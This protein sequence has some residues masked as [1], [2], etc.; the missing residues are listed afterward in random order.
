[1]RT[2]S[3][4]LTRTNARIYADEA[5]L[6]NVFRRLKRSLPTGYGDI[7]IKV[8]GFGHFGKFTRTTTNERAIVALLSYA[9][10]LVATDP[11]R[12]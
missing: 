12:I 1:M 3:F 7:Y 9:T 8:E 2:V 5:A 11:N 6:I 4:N 10:N